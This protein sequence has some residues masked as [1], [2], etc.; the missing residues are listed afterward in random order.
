MGGTARGGEES[1][2]CSC[3]SL[4]VAPNWKPSSWGYSQNLELCHP[5]CA[6]EG[7]PSRPVVPWG[8]GGREEGR[9]G[10]CDGEAEQRRT[11]WGECALSSLE[12]NSWS[13]LEQ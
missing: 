6:E 11:V 10:A 12:G 8:G 5:T 1:D 2:T 13:S 9:G 3:V 7:P 4:T